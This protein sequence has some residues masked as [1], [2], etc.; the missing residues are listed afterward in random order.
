M[1]YEQEARLEPDTYIEG[2][3]TLDPAELTAVLEK[4]LAEMRSYRE[5]KTAWRTTFISSDGTR[6]TPELLTRDQYSER[7]ATLESASPALTYDSDIDTLGIHLSNAKAVRTDE[8]T[9]GVLVDFD[10]AGNVITVEILDVT[11]RLKLSKS[12]TVES[13]HPASSHNQG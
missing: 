5:G 11:R 8:V 2:E 6:T 1:T 12:T 10:K 9:S 3:D 13:A 4:S 7:H